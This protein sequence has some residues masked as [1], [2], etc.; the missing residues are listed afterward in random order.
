MFFYFV[1]SFFSVNREFNKM[2]K[3]DEI[4][5][6]INTDHLSADVKVSLFTSAAISFKRDS[7]LSP[8]P[9]LYLVDGVK[10]FEK[11]VSDESSLS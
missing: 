3:L 6:I 1:S 11:L 9:K 7:L 4:K 5:D 10:N 8:F 2:S